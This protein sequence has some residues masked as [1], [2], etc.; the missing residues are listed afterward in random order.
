MYI[1]YTLFIIYTL[2]IYIHTVYYIHCK[3]I[4]I[5]IIITIFIIDPVVV[6]SRLY[7]KLLGACPGRVPMAEG[8]GVAEGFVARICNAK[9]THLETMG[10]CGF[11]MGFIVDLW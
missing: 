6:T 5:Y 9:E 1:I 7:S 11:F 4:Y 10:K 8:Y 3:Y 2:Y